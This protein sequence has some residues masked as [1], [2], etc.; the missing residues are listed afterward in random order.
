MLSD[1]GAWDPVGRYFRTVH[2]GRPD[3]IGR[4]SKEG[5]IFLQEKQ[6]TR[7]ATDLISFLDQLQDRFLAFYELAAFP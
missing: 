6:R 4:A 2:V 3:D 1:G 7:C 5:F